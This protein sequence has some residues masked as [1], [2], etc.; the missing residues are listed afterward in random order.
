MDIKFESGQSELGG[1][2]SR[3]IQIFQI[4]S[5]LMVV[6]FSYLFLQLHCSLLHKEHYILTFIGTGLQ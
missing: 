2:I 4:R 5:F 6:G 3:N 1:L